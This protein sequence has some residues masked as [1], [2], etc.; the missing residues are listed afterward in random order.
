MNGP[1]LRT[2]LEHLYRTY[3]RVLVPHDPVFLVHRYAEPDDREVVGLV[4]SSLAFGRVQSILQSI[5]RVLAIMGPSPA[6][7]VRAFE[8]RQ[9]SL[10]DRSV[11]RW[12][13]GRDVACLA[14]FIRQMLNEAG[15]I[16]AFFARGYDPSHEDVGP[17]LDSFS[18]RSLALDWRAIYG[19][20]ASRSRPRATSVGTIPRT[21]VRYFFPRPSDGSG[22]KRLNL[23]LRWM[24]RRDEIDTGAWR[25]VPAS[26]LVVPLDTHVIR[27]GRCL[28]LTRRAS[29]GWQM[30]QEITRALRAC[31][32]DDPVKYDFALCHAG[33]HGLCGF[34]RRGG[35]R[36][37][38]LKGLCRPYRRTATQRGPRA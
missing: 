3:D 24:V 1:D 5:D 15:S 4:A 31:D 18:E 8:P 13:R 11:H 36:D 20:P 23:Y 9:A 12:S 10:F 34:G 6:R 29:P 35:D 7:F 21:G 17:A 2:R 25:S 26:K 16:E 14:W 19:A 38:P 37:C 22:C 28:R 33:M 32:P 30:A 27:L